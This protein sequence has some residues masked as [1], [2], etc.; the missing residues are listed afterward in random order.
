M[1]DTKVR[2]CRGIEEAVSVPFLGEIPLSDRKTNSKTNILVSE[3]GR[4]PLTETFR[5]LR[6]NINFMSRDGKEVQVITLTSF[7]I[8]VGKTFTSLNLA[9]TLSYLGKKVAVVDLDLRKGSL[10]SRVGL[11]GKKGVSHYLANPTIQIKD[12]QHISSEIPNLYFFPIGAIA[13]NPVELLLSKRLDDL[14]QILRDQY[15]YIIVDSVPIGI[16]ADAAVV[17]RISDLTLFMI[18]VGKMDRRQLPD[19]ERIYREKKINNLAVVLN[20]LKLG[21]SGY[22]CVLIG[23]QT[24]DCQKRRNSINIWAT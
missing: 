10:T 14:I 12:I 15:D 23:K 21:G 22:G 24:D 20:G 5:I 6:T 17:D 1:L 16:V 13:P 18:R 9:T 3:T 7:G 8:G 19:I 11:D 4:D 2:S